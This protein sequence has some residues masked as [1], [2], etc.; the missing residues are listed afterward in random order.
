MRYHFWGLLDSCLAAKAGVPVELGLRVCIMEDQRQFI[1]HHQAMEK[2][3]DDAI[4]VEMVSQTRKRFPEL[5]IASFDKGF[6][7]KANQA[8]L[9]NHLEQVILPKKGRLS[10]ADKTHE[11]SDEFKKL[12]NQHSGVEPAINALGQNGLDRCPDHGIKGFKC[13]VAL[14]VVSRNIKRLGAVIRQ[15]ALEKGQRKRGPYKKAA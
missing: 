9:L 4:A 2:Q 13:Y 10:Q 1:L 5:A 7:S 6:H 3:T 15:Q 11:G 8:E 14:A 12:R